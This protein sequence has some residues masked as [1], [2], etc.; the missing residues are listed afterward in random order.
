MLNK[1]E[2]MW[3]YE[4]TSKGIKCKALHPKYIYTKSGI[5]KYISYEKAFNKE[6]HI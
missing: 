5:F 4:F 3:Q 2:E 6:E 1:E